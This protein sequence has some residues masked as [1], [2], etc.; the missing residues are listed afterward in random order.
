M[1]WQIAQAAERDAL[2]A[3]W[4]PTG[5][6]FTYADG[7]PLKRGQVIGVVCTTGNA[8]PNVQDLHFA[9]AR[10]NDVKQW[11]KGMP[12]NPYPLLAPY[13]AGPQI[14]RSASPRTASGCSSVPRPFSLPDPRTLGPP[15]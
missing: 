7:Q 6:V 10:S 9:I 8:Q 5:Y 15:D 1:A 13:D 4:T 2:G 11:W 14:R 12:V 3:D